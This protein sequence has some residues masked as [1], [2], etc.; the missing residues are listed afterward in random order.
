MITIEARLI[1]FECDTGGYINYIFENLNCTN[2]DNQFKLVTRYPNWEHRSLKIGEE[3]FLTY[4][5]VEAGISNWYNKNT[6]KM[7]PYKYTTCE[8]IKFIIKK[9]NQDQEYIM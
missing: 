3:G 5:M 2:W 7:T 6:G 4:N 1:S 9:Q 8:F